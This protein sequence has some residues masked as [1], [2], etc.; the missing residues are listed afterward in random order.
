MTFKVLIIEDN[1]SFI[2]S[3]KVMLRDLPLWKV[4]FTQIHAPKFP[5]LVDQLEFL[6]DVVEEADGALTVTH[7]GAVASLRV[8]P[9]DDDLELLPGE[10]RLFEARVSRIVTRK[11]SRSPGRTG[12]RYLTLSELIRSAVRPSLEPRRSM[13]TPAAWGERRADANLPPR[14]SL[15]PRTAV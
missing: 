5:H 12:L 8:V 13:R 10:G 15:L 4:E 11:V 9:I 7:G 3:L 6:A 2:D 14:A 1:H